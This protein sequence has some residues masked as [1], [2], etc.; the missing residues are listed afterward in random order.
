MK[1]RNVS[2]AYIIP[3]EMTKIGDLRLSVSAQNLIAFTNY[4][5]FDP[6]V[7]NTQNSDTDQGLDFGVYPMPRLVTFGM[8]LDF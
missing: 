6:E 5:G 7:S 1:I 4:K 8:T 3:Q 2:L